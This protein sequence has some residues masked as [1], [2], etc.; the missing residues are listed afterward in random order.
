MTCSCILAFSIMAAKTA[1]L[2]FC[3]RMVNKGELCK[4]I[5]MHNVGFL[6][7]DFVMYSKDLTSKLKIKISK[8]YLLNGR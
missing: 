8:Y 6:R 7:G 1:G 4:V 5:K 3:N 2:T